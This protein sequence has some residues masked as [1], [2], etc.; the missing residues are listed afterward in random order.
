MRSLGA[1]T[2]GFVLLGEDTPKRMQ[3]HLEE[4][5]DLGDLSLECSALACHGMWLV[6][7]R[8]ICAAEVLAGEG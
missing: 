7:G 5:L 8:E 1:E 2:I 6:G 4:L 3:T